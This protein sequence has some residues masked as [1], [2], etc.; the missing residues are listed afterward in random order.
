MVTTE[1]PPA[2]PPRTHPRTAASAALAWLDAGAWT[3]AAYF[4]L[5]DTNHIVELSE[6]RLLVHEMPNLEHQRIVDELGFAI[7]LLI[8]EHAGGRKFSS[9]TPVRLWEGKIREPDL[10]YYAAGREDCYHVQ[11]AD[12]PDLAIEV[13]SPSTR[14]IDREEKAAEYADAGVTEYWIVDPE[15]RSIE[16][17]TGAGSEGYTSHRQFGPGDEVTSTV[18]PGL[19]VSVAT[20][21]PAE[22]PLK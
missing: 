3:E 15:G 12:P 11:Y 7:N 4:A 8:R 18:L 9:P 20:L 6:G 14:H 17:L 1:A 19:V 5:P 10:V 21:I 2:A 13:L 16:V 22:S